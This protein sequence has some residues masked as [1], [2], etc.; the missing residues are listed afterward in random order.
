MSKY[1]TRHELY[2]IRNNIPIAEVLATLG[3]PHQTRGG[4]I[5][6]VCPQCSESITAINPRTNLGRCFACETNYNPIDL[7][8]LINACDF[9]VAV[10]FLQKQF[11]QSL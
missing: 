4:R 5:R 8:M 3:W 7:V 9:V 6:F 2:K 10:Q 1:F 11:P